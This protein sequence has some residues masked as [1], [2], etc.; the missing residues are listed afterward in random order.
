MLL[1]DLCIGIEEQMDAVDLRQV[2]RNVDV[3][4]IHNCQVFQL[5]RIHH[6]VF[7]EQVEFSVAFDEER[8]GRRRHAITRYDDLMCNF[9]SMLYVMF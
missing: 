9:R 4:E 1:T 3:I 7:D 2:G 8:F 5:Q 6:R